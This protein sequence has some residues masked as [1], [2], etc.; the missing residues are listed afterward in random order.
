MQSQTPKHIWDHS[1]S[2]IGENKHLN[3]YLYYNW[4]FCML[5]CTFNVK[6]KAI[7]YSKLEK[8]ICILPY[9]KTC[10][11]C[12][13]YTP[14]KVCRSCI[15]LIFSAF[16][17]YWWLLTLLLVKK[18]FFRISHCLVMCKRLSKMQNRL[19]DVVFSHY[20]QKFSLNTC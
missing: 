20:L 7:R 8:S 4:G 10:R 6:Q 14:S 3:Q 5:K 9:T 17:N 11:M 1:P 12:F 2:N 15:F 18:C 19:P 16:H 13:F